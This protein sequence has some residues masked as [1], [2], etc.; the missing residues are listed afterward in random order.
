MFRPEQQPLLF[1]AWDSDTESNH[2]LWNQMHMSL[3]LLHSLTA[4]RF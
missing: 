2:E 1:S 4:P 3:Y